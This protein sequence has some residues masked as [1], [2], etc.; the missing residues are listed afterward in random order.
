MVATSVDNKN[1]SN[2]LA[3]NVYH[4]RRTATTTETVTAAFCAR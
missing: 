3:V 2:T 1:K 4:N